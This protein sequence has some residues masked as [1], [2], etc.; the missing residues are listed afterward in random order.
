MT[1]V[2]FTCLRT[3]LDPSK[4][5]ADTKLEASLEMLVEFD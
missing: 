4:V 3:A 2:Q 1:L 5:K